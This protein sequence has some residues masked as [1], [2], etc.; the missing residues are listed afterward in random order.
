MGRGA[1][2]AILAVCAFVL[3]AAIIA[4]GGALATTLS[5]LTI[6]TPSGERHFEVEVAATPSERSMGLMYR[7]DMPQDRGM[8][9]DFGTAQPVSMWMKNTYVPLDMVFIREDGIVHRVAMRTEPHSERSISAGAPVRYVLEINGG[10]A[11]TLGIVP[12][13]RVRH[14]RIEGS[15]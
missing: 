12:G 4:A 13:S 5:P 15:S 2:G 6:E 9:F 7:R 8:L 1:A 11:E 10:V 3:L 14:E